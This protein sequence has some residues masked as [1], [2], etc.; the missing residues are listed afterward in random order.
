MLIA[1]RRLLR[2]EPQRREQE[3]LST[4]LAARGVSCA[5]SSPV[6]HTP[7]TAMQGR[8][9]GGALIIANKCWTPVESKGHEKLGAAILAPSTC[10]VLKLYQHTV[11]HVRIAICA[12]YGHP[13]EK[14]RTKADLIVITEFLDALEDHITVVM[15]DYNIDDEAGQP[16]DIMQLSNTHWDT[17]LHWAESTG[18]PTVPTCLHT[19]STRIDR[20]LLGQRHIQLLNEVSVSDV[21]LVPQHQ[22]VRARLQATRVHYTTHTAPPPIRPAQPPLQVELDHGPCQAQVRRH[23]R[24]HN[25]TAAYETWSQ[26]F[27]HYLHLKAGKTLQ[28]S[29]KQQAQHPQ[30]RAYEWT[31]KPRS[32]ATLQLAKFISKLRTLKN[33]H[34]RNGLMAQ[35]LWQSIREGVEHYSSIYGSPSIPEQQPENVEALTTHILE[36]TFSYYNNQLLDIYKQQAFDKMQQHKERLHQHGGANKWVSQALNVKKIFSLAGVVHNNIKETRIRPTLRILREELQKIF[37][38]QRGLPLEEWQQRYLQQ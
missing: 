19:R 30:T 27:E 25:S 16:Q 8:S 21:P 35:R 26:H 13:K 38:T 33:M 15:G 11:T 37:E 29:P 24:A 7:G 5:W 32:S 10:W 20:I 34:Q 1:S 23:L 28:H 4:A 18:L 3:M 22:T 14:Q 12:Y 17:Q 6:Q 31:A 9:G 36:A 2:P